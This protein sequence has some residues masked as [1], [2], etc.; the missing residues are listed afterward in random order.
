MYSSNNQIFVDDSGNNRAII[1]N[2]TTFS[3]VT[4]S[5]N[6]TTP[7][8]RLPGYKLI[9]L[10]NVVV[11]SRGTFSLRS[12]QVSVNGTQFGNV[13]HLGGGTDSGNNTSYD[14]ST[15]FDPTVGDIGGT[16]ENYTLN[17]L[18]SDFDTVN[19]FTNNLFY[20]LPFTFNSFNVSDTKLQ[21]FTF[22]VNKNQIQRIKDNLDHF[23]VWYTK[24]NTTP[25]W[26][27]YIPNIA[28]TQI[29]DNGTVVA[30]KTDGT[31]FI[32]SYIFKIVAV[33]HWQNRQ[34]S[35]LL[36]IA[37]TGPVTKTNYPSFTKNFVTPAPTTTANPSPTVSPVPTPSST[38]EITATSNLQLDKSGLLKLIFIISSIAALILLITLSKRRSRL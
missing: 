27:G 36:Y 11:G 19:T 38:N 26:V 31:R 28:K 35:D 17:F 20:F 21:T 4:P 32:G 22:T 24:N 34:D 1:Y 9:A 15:D 10:G 16:T 29:N 6:L 3:V 8:T 7:L 37:G 13:T 30:T 33:D 12:L 14:F 2:N 18:A 23:E 5:I 25:K